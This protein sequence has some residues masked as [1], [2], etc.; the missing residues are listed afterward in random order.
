[1]PVEHAPK[2]HERNH[3]PSPEKVA[4]NL[5]SYKLGFD[6]LRSQPENF[7]Q[8]QNTRLGITVLDDQHY[9]IEYDGVFQP[10][11]PTGRTIIHRDTIDLVL[12]GDQAGYAFS[13]SQILND[14]VVYQTDPIKNT[15][16]AAYRIKKILGIWLRHVEEMKKQFGTTQSSL[17]LHEESS[18][19]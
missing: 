4:A 3:I 5:N 13:Q 17:N 16:Q 11:L 14:E 19:A 18:V 12:Q 1:M 8:S 9:H 7:L 2:Y 15:E 6:T 10:K